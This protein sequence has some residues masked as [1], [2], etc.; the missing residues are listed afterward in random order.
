MAKRIF[1]DRNFLPNE[2]PGQYFFLQSYLW[3]NVFWSL[4]SLKRDGISIHDY[5]HSWSEEERRD[6]CLRHSTYAAN[7]R[8]LP[9]E[10]RSAYLHGD[11]EVFGG[12][13]F[14]NFDRKKQVIEPFEVPG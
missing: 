4:R 12:M 6:Y 8:S 1:I 13:F 10:L 9:D 2:D 11:W 7:L 14:R 3:D 5:Y